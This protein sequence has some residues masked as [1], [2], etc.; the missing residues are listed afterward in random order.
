M[1]VTHF[2]NVVNVTELF[3]LKWL[4]LCYLKFTSIK[5]THTHTEY[6]LKIWIQRVECVNPLSG[7]PQ[8]CS[9][10]SVPLLQPLRVCFSFLL[11][12]WLFI[13]PLFVLIC[14]RPH[15]C[16]WDSSWIF[17]C[18]L[19]GLRSPLS[20]S[21]S[22]SPSSRTWPVEPGGGGGSCHQGAPLLVVAWPPLRW[23]T[24]PFGL[25]YLEKKQVT[26]Q[27]PAQGR[28]GSISWLALQHHH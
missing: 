21:L 20:S 1:M 3:T 10:P 8:Q 14:H 26:A 9:R 7:Q 12:A 6:F 24:H 25:F 17:T 2:V 4:I 18:H 19:A 5:H 23:V 28:R 15:V 22:L 11:T 16:R 27:E 13:E